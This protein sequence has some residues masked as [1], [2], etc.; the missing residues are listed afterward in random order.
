MTLEMTCIKNIKLFTEI[1]ELLGYPHEKLMLVLN[2]ADNRLGIRVENVENNIKHKVALQI[3]NA[4]F[5]MTLSINQGVPMVIAKREHR[6]SKDIF[7][8]ARE[9]ARMAGETVP[10]GAPKE[11]SQPALKQKEKGDGG[12]L[13]RLFSSR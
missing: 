1:A 11:S 12:F 13:K 9:L 4:P 2:K 8:L 10:E 3:A 5:E 6:A 7:A